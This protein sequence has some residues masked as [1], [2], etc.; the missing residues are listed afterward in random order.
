L[1]GTSEKE[2]GQ[3]AAPTVVTEV[4]APDRKRNE[5]EMKERTTRLSLFLLELTCHCMLLAVLS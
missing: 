3:N 5:K 2:I 1:T 4:S